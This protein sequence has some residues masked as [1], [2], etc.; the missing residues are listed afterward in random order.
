[1]LV[2]GAGV[3]AGYLGRPELTD[4]RFV[5]DPAGG[6][7]YRT[8]DL[9]RY[10]P[11]GDLEFLGRIDDQVKLRGHR[12]ELG[13]VE[14]VLREHPGVRDA[15]AVV[16]EDGR[17]D[18]R[19]L[20]YVVPEGTAGA[21]G[22]GEDALR[23]HARTR[24][25]VYMVPSVISALAELP[26]TPS[27]KVDRAA[28][29]DPQADAVGAGEPAPDREPRDE[30]ERVIRDILATA[31]EADTFGVEEDF[32]ARGGHSLLAMRVLE[33]VRDRLSATV[34][35]RRFFERPTAAGL[36]DAV[37]GDDAAAG[38]DPREDVRLDPEVRPGTGRTARTGGPVLVTGASGFLGGFVLAELLGRGD[39]EVV[40]LVRAEDARSGTERLIA[41]LGGL[42]VWQETWRPRLR[43][44]PG[45]LTRP[46]LG[47]DE[48]EF[49]HLAGEITAIYHVGANVNL[50]LPY[51]SLRGTNVAGTHEV[52]RLAAAGGVPVHHVST[53]SVFPMEERG[54]AP[55]AESELPAD[56]P[57]AE[58]A[59]N[60]SKWVAEGVVR[61]ARERG[62]PVAVYRPGRITGDTS[63]GAWRTDDMICRL[64][65]SFVATGTA[66][67]VDLR[68]D[69]QA[70]DALASA[71][72][73]LAD[74]PD[75]LG[76]EFHFRAPR[77]VAIG[78]LVDVLNAIG[79]QVERVT[80]Q[81]WYER[82]RDGSGDAI[83]ATEAEMFRRRIEHHT[84]G[85]SEPVL[86]CANTER[87]LG[88]GAPLPQIDQTIMRRYVERMIMTGFLP[89]PSA[90]GDRPTP[91]ED[92]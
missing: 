86:D 87:L 1:L 63:G 15:A 25:P 40:C 66:P 12:I 81:E 16:R 24:L 6:R 73:R 61:L 55:H 4:D 31:L 75:A 21:A 50:V 8:G 62:I 47:L 59:Y 79:Y 7:A 52:L 3:G 36:A 72:V 82:C 85:M 77:P 38:P 84:S 5:P 90:R 68:T 26:L 49:G 70:V 48:E 64:V 60:Q 88:P 69:M 78:E 39:G 53:A 14:Q 42:G 41:N 57:P 45:D 65:R 44:L 2:G 18:A 67:D 30:T 11:G 92:N 74:T 43:A 54:A 22:P 23:A 76:N 71:I 56:P 20:A 28:L 80:T 13:E 29:P 89:P 10:R 91:D 19:L 33:D 27:R 32:F 58:I 17:G 35:I 83:S 51:S 9:V 34:P 46:R 37:R